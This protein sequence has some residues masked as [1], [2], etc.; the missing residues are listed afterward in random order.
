MGRFLRMTPI[1]HYDC[2][3]KSREAIEESYRASSDPR[4]LLQQSRD[5]IAEGR[6]TIYAANRRLEESRFWRGAVKAHLLSSRCVFSRLLFFF[7]SS[8]ILKLGVGGLASLNV[9]TYVKRSSRKGLASL[10]LDRQ[11]EGALAP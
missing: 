6:R 11:S 7:F 5:A 9:A 1:S 8:A 10:F 2:M 3:E 4:P